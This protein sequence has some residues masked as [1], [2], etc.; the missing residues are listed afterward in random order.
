MYIYAFNRNHGQRHGKGPHASPN[1]LGLRVASVKTH[2][3]SPGIDDRLCE[4]VSAELAL[5]M[6][7]EAGEMVEWQE[8]FS[9]K[10][11]SPR[12]ASRQSPNRFAGGRR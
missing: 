5:G 11:R 9:R 12:S 1:V 6:L 4:A 8:T 2:S 10:L 7:R 3:Q